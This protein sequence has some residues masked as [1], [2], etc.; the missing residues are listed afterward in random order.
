MKIINIQNGT[1]IVGHD[2]AKD[3]TNDELRDVIMRL[4]NRQNKNYLLDMLRE[5]VDL[6]SDAKEFIG[7]DGLPYTEIEI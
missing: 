3:L 6:D 1:L 4:L 2:R 5:M 7:L